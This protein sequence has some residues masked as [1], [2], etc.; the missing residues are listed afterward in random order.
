MIFTID[1]R[2]FKLFSQKEEI[3]RATVIADGTSA[4]LCNIYIDKSFRNKGLCQKM[5]KEILHNLKQEG[6]HSV[7][8]TVDP[9]NQKAVHIYKKFGFQTVEKS[10]KAKADSQIQ[11]QNTMIKFFHG[12]R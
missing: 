2:D 3:G 9:S 10:F 8:L 1:N 12:K 11:E 6:F 4:K 7:D 5:L